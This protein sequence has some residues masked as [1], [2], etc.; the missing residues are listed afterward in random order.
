IPSQQTP[1]KREKGRKGEWCRE[2]FQP[3]T[4]YRP[5]TKFGK[6]HNT[7]TPF[8]SPTLLAQTGGVYTFKEPS[9]GIGEL[10]AQLERGELK[11]KKRDYFGSGLCNSLKRDE[12][13]KNGEK[14]SLLQ[15]FAPL[16]QFQIQVE[17]EKLEDWL[18]RGAQS[19]LSVEKLA[20]KK[21][22]E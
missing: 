3:L 20:S 1:G 22:L 7:G 18:K 9:V 6:Y 10:L 16:V 21:E 19:Q 14:R 2:L 12:C 17:R 8:K 4:F 13:G 11:L 5:V 15:G